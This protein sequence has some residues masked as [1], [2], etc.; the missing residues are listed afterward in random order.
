MRQ[1]IISY[2]FKPVMRKPAFCICVNKGADQPLCTLHSPILLFPKSEISCLE[3]SSVVVQPSL[4]QTRLDTPKT[5]FLMTRLISST[6]L[7]F[8]EW[9]TEAVTDRTH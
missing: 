5:G 2:D 7:G 8:S 9:N 4:C 1:L 3:P 6:D